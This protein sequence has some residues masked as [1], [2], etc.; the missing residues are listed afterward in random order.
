MLM[1]DGRTEL[2][3]AYAQEYGQSQTGRWI[4]R[5]ILLGQ[6]SPRSTMRTIACRAFG[7]SYDLP[8]LIVDM[9]AD[10]F[11]DDDVVTPDEACS[12]SELFGA[13]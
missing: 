9:V 8:E 10:A 1:L 6:I 2:A 11:W 3:R 7:V 13:R 5:S 4:K 12:P